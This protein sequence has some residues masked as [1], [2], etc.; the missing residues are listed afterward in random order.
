MT[1]AAAT[2]GIVKN[3]IENNVYLALA[4][5]AGS[6]KR[7]RMQLT[8]KG[9]SAIY[10]FNG[11]KLKAAGP[12]G[13]EVLLSEIHPQKTRDKSFNPINDILSDRQPQHYRELTRANRNQKILATKDRRQF[14]E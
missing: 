5:R 7:D 14:I 12:T 6:E 2:G 4:N 10:D 1:T 9:K 13:D 11:R 3:A 8:F